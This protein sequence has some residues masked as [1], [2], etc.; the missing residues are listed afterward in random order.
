MQDPLQFVIAGDSHIFAM[1]AAQSYLGPLE[2]VRTQSPDDNGFFLMEQWHGVRGPAYWQKLNECVRG[3]V[4]VLQ[5]MGNQHFGNFLLARPPLFDVVDCADASGEIFPAA[6]IVPRRMLKDLPVFRGD[7]VRQIVNDLHAH[8]CVQVIICG[9][10][11]VRDDY[12]A[13]EEVIRTTSFFQDKAR[14]LGIDIATC[15]FTPPP[16]MKRLWGVLQECLGDI[17]HSTHSLFLAVP[18]QSLDANGYL[19]GQFRGPPA[20]FT[21]PNNAY[22]LLMFKQIV[23]A[24]AAVERDLRAGA[25][26]VARPQTPHESPS[27]GVSSH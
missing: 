27:T 6:R 9:T 17:A 7:R 10:P 21:H 23:R 15:R 8:G 4:A 22:G 24:V 18:A 16:I 26:G 5:V 12:T 20:N 1:G 14:E 25:S 13:R 11:P 2:L 3:R 19:A